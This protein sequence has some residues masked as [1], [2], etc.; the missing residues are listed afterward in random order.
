MNPAGQNAAVLNPWWVSVMEMWGCQTITVTGASAVTQQAESK[1][2]ISG[3]PLTSFFWNNP[4]HKSNFPGPKNAFDYQLP[5][6][7]PDKAVFH[8]S[9]FSLYS[10]CWLTI[11]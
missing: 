7:E 6:F 8:L 2:L 1:I 9:D 4:F 3:I 10:K 5:V 11:L